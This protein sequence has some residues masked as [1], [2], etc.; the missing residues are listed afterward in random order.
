MT[1]VAQAMLDLQK[2]VRA[3]LLATPA[4]VTAVPG[5]FHDGYPDK[6]GDDTAL[7]LLVFTGSEPDYEGT[8]CMGE[9]AGNRHV[10]LNLTMELHDDSPGRITTLQAAAAVEAALDNGVALTL[11]HGTARGTPLV[12]PG[13]S[14]PSDATGLYALPVTVRQLIDN[15]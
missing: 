11:A 8:E 5:G 9:T 15:I 4:V 6:I 13:R 3:K 7:P 12:R 14:N 2:A 1:G 10:W